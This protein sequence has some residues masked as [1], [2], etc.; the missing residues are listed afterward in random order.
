MQA[1]RN[2][3]LGP[4]D[5]RLHLFEGKSGSSRCETRPE[6]ID[7]DDWVRCAKEA[8]G[9]EKPD[10]II[11]GTEELAHRWSR[12]TPLRCCVAHPVEDQE[13]AET[14]APGNTV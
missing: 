1:E 13:A 9:D 3:L 8:A 5:R 12:R 10:L 4:R 6:G 14:A 7:E 2:R 11:F